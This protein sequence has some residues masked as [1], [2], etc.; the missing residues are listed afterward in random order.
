M[1]GIYDVLVKISMVNGVSPVI[2][3]IARDL[4]GLHGSVNSLSRTLKTA[5]GATVIGTGLAALGFKEVIHHAKGLSHELTQLQKLGI[6]DLQLSEARASALETTRAVRGVTEVEAL[7]TYGA[8]YSIFGH[9]GALKLMKPLAEFAQVVGNNSESYDRAVENVY[10]MVRAGDLMGKFVNEA[11]HK[12][13]PDKLQHFLDLGAKVVS[14][15]HGYVNEN[16]WL[17]MAQQGGPALS[18]MSDR[19]LITMALLSQAMGGYRAGTAMMSE[20]QQLVGGRMPQYAGKRLHELGLVGDYTV[21]RGGHLIW[22]EGALDTE[23]IRLL[24][25]DQLKGVEFL[26]GRLKERGYDTTDK[27]VP[28]LFEIFGR[29]TTVRAIHD[30]VRNFPQMM[31]EVPRIEAGMGVKDAKKAADE[32]DIVQAERNFHAAWTNMM[33]AIAGPQSKNAIAVLDKL[34]EF[35]RWI[36]EKVRTIDFSTFKGIIE[37]LVDTVRGIFGQIAA[38]WAMISEGLSRLYKLATDAAQGIIDLA[39]AIAELPGKIKA[40]ILGMSQLPG[41][42]N[43]R[44]PLGRH[45][46][47]SRYGPDGARIPPIPGKQSNLTIHNHTYLDGRQVAY[48]VERHLVDHHQYPTR[49]PGGDGFAMPA[50]G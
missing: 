41:D 28:V 24:K 3:V 47:G 10:K 33:V 30:M 12:V 38:G 45:D 44:G 19:G 29:Q 36:G 14:S 18:G 42:Y 49:A 15:T 11:T 5:F 46:D 40:A 21:G 1:S 27:M 20:F 17:A 13:D 32:N 37:R 50:Y 9:E 48:S 31:G 22:N 34:A 35:F 25:D 16:T 26:M 39:N 8:T 2:A 4:L 6:G 23:F 7:K 43:S